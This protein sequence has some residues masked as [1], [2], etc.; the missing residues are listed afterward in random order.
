MPA[1]SRKSWRR[2]M[3]RESKQSAAPQARPRSRPA[4]NR[5]RSCWNWRR[6]TAMDFAAR[7]AF[8]TSTLRATSSGLWSISGI[9]SA[10]ARTRSRS[11][12]CSTKSI[13][14]GCQPAAH[15]WQVHRRH[16]RH[17][18]RRRPL[19]RHLHRH[20]HRHR[21]HRPQHQR[22]PQ[23]RHQ[24]QH[25][26]AG[27]RRLL[28]VSMGATRGRRPLDAPMALGHAQRPHQ[29]RVQGTAESPVAS[30]QARYANRIRLTPLHCSINS[31]PRL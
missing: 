21:H 14:A 7:Q 4:M 30:A 20:R 6:S 10:D 9:E 18:L 26:V 24:R 8:R 17:R 27:L 13:S 2:S 16:R 22:Q 23:L 11:R 31:G 19:H 12:T 29:A 1:R 5:W 15:P 28:P 3:G 25:S